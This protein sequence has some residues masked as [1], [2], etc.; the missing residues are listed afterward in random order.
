MRIGIIGAGQLGQMLGMAA[1][2]LGMDCQFIDPSADPPAAACGPVIQAAYDD[3]D[4]L[5]SG[6][7]SKLQP[8]DQLVFM[9]NGGFG[10]VR[11]K[12]TAALNNRR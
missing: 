11:Q 2:E 5:I 1:R 7:A 3:Y 12:L 6:I 9:S 4:A 8:G 10:A